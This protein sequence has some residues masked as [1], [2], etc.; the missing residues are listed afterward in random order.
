MKLLRHKI[1][2]EK[3]Q[4]FSKKEQLLN[5]A[6]EISRIYHQELQEKERSEQTMTAYERAL[7]LVDLT[8]QDP[9][10]HGCSE[11]FQLRDAICALYIGKT[12]PAI[13]KFFY[14]WLVNFSQ[15]I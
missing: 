3:W 13:G 11:L 14:T 8:L 7:E 1:E 5:I 2:K 12:H 15:N 9:K 4:A 6:S 10:W